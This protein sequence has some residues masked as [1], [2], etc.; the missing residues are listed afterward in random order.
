MTTCSTQYHTFLLTKKKTII[1][2]IN[3]NTA[4]IRRYINQNIKFRDTW[5]KIWIEQICTT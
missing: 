1:L 5:I 2:T 3:D 4:V